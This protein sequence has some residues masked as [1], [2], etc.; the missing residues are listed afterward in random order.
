MEV[1]VVFLQKI[2]VQCP[3]VVVASKHQIRAFP[4]GSPCTRG[5]LMK[6]R[7]A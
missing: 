7:L 6:T 5:F 4:F 1:S 2:Q 3:L